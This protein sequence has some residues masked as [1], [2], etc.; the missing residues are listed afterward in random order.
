M[1]NADFECFCW[2]QA[3]NKRV[4]AQKHHFTLQK[5]KRNKGKVWIMLL[6]SQPHQGFLAY[7]VG[8]WSFSARTLI[9]HPSLWPEHKDAPPLSFERLSWHIV[10][11]I[12]WTAEVLLTTSQHRLSCNGPVNQST[13][14]LSV[15]YLP[16]E[17][18]S[19]YF[20]SLNWLA[21]STKYSD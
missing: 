11:I 17:P 8:L 12:S 15:Q 16:S 5:K 7:L 21:R 20:L 10:L 4:W 1:A 18:D 14:A 3:E 13:V 9:L 6:I 2:M 19:L